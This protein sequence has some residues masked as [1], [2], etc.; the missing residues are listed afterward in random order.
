MGNQCVIYLGNG[1]DVALGY[2]T[3]YSQFIENSVFLQLENKCQLA[4]W[5]KQKYSEDKNRW[6]DLEELLYEYSW[7][8]YKRYNKS[9]EFINITDI[10]KE[11]HRHLT[12]ALQ[13]YICNQNSSDGSGSVPLLEKSWKSYLDIKYICCFNYTANAVLER[14]LPDYLLLDRIHGALTPHSKEKEVKIKLGIDRSMV[15]CNEHEFLYKDNMPTYAYGIW[16][17]PSKRLKAI[18]TDITRLPLSPTFSNVDVIIIY[19]CSLGKSDTA[20]F[21]YLFDNA[22]EKRILLYHYGDK[23][24]M[25]IADRIREISKYPIDKIIFIDSSK[26]NGYIRDFPELLKDGL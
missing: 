16:Q 20:Y 9:Q 12:L 26:D 11:D 18:S 1:Y 24:K 7:Y 10:F 8:I 6:C 4:D 21:K 23:E 5:I 3:R 15:V 17:E 25:K 19:G 14:L 13:D 2:K 22:A